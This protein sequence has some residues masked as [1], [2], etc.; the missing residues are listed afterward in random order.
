M[1]LSKT[2]LSIR[3]WIEMIVSFLYQ[4]EKKEDNIKIHEKLIRLSYWV[5]FACNIIQ[6]YDSSPFLE[7]YI[8]T[9]FKEITN[10]INNTDI[11][12]IKDSSAIQLL[13]KSIETLSTIPFPQ[14]EILNSELKELLEK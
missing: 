4:R 6:E 8:L 13:L 12:S 14:I 2:V 7:N 5:N 9:T 1:E 3:K 11:D 10:T